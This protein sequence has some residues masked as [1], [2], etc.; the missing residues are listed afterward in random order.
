MTRYDSNDIRQRALVE[1]NIL[2]SVI[3]DSN[4]RKNGGFKPTL[5]DLILHDYQISS[6]STLNAILSN[7]IVDIAY[8]VDCINNHEYTVLA[9][10]YFKIVEGLD[11][12][13]ILPNSTKLLLDI[14]G[15]N[16]TFKTRD[17]V[18]D[19]EKLDLPEGIDEFVNLNSVWYGVQNIRDDD[20]DVV[21]SN[22]EIVDSMNRF[23][24]SSDV[25]NPFSD[26]PLYPVDDAGQRDPNPL[27][28][29]A[30]EW[31]KS[32]KLKV[33]S[34]VENAFYDNSAFQGMHICN[35]KYILCC[36]L[37]DSEYSGLLGFGTYQENGKLA[38]LVL[39]DIGA[40]SPNFISEM[41]FKTCSF[42]AIAD[43]TTFLFVA[44]EKSNSDK[45]KYR[46]FFLNESSFDPKY[47]FSEIDQVVVDGLT[48]AVDKAFDKVE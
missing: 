31:F 8:V 43:E 2:K 16:G 34:I 7:Y 45:P 46:Y 26:V 17:L 29:S 33:N 27:A 20:G 41:E 4:R 11:E 36:T 35:C 32:S 9:D 38:G 12:N 3:L 1:S 48:I 19:I 39:Y 44:V 30:N 22:M 42:H 40:E 15:D 25:R 6:S 21:Y 37:P 13:T 5:D 18:L 10:S 23:Y 47:G 24:D 28:A 14:D